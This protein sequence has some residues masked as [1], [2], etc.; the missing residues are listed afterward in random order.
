MAGAMIALGILLSDVK[1]WYDFFVHAGEILLGF[2]VSPTYFN[3][4]LPS[5]VTAVGM[6][7]H[8]PQESAQVM[9]LWWKAGAVIGWGLILG[10]YFACLS[11]ENAIELE[12]SILTVAMLVGSVMAWGYYF[13][14]L[15]FPVA[16]ALANVR[17]HSS[18]LHVY[19]LATSL[20][21]LNCFS[22]REL[23][24]MPLIMGIVAN[25]FPLAGLFGLGAIFLSELWGNRVSSRNALC[26]G[27]EPTSNTNKEPLC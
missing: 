12:F 9:Y 23:A 7:L 21:L 17:E 20:M 10:T 6:I 14:F 5:L 2:V 8:G 24:K 11:N 18:R 22:L 27:M 15:I 1:L 26:A 13:V 4:S 25:Y 3:Y 19:G 16:H